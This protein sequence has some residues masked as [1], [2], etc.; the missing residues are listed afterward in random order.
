MDLI[1]LYDF[2]KYAKEKIE[3]SA[4]DYY[5]GGA[6]D[7]ITLIENI[8]A[9]QRIKL[10][11]RVLRNVA[12]RDLTTTVLNQKISCPIIIAPTGMLGMAHPDGER[13][14]SRASYGFQTIMTLSTLSNEAMEDVKKESEYPLW[15]QLY[16]LKDRAVTEF[17]VRRVERAGYS[18]LVLTVDAPVLGLRERDTRN[19]FK[20]PNSLT[21]KNL[22]G[23]IYHSMSAS[24]D[25][26]EYI[27]N[28]FD[29]SIS[30]RDVEW[31][32]SITSLP[33]IVKGILSPQD[34][35]I[36]IEHGAKGIICSNHGGRQLDTVVA[37][38]DALPDIVKVVEGK[39]PVLI[40]GGIRRGTDILKAIALGA[41]AVLI[42]RPTIWGLAYKGS[43]G[44][45]KVLEILKS[46]LD[47]A[48][49]LCGFSSI[50]Q[51]KEEGREIIVKSD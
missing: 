45:N 16:I 3:K 33:V 31:L 22:T 26:A 24:K 35:I 18:A 21:L 15:F 48:M 47:I 19:H 50:E 49:A 20:M 6:N 23:S 4:Y 14:V 8:R 41:D 2:E 9:Y 11:P 7:E 28:T 34:A 17:V 46:E 27:A 44:V 25:L 51:L 12:H 10:Q 1:S 42:G 13:A 38:I 37:T 40:D 36:A 30:W 5:A 39:V 43:V 32:V 29:P